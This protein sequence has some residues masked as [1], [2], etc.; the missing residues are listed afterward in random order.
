MEIST[1]THA[2]SIDFFIKANIKDLVCFC[3]TQEFTGEDKGMQNPAKI[4][5]KTAYYKD[6]P[7]KNFCT[8]TEIV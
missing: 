2:Q 6:D 4:T 7:L 3:L 8:C 1:S 5:H